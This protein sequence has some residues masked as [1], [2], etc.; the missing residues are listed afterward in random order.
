MLAHPCLPR[1]RSHPK[2]TVA[3][4]PRSAW[5]TTSSPDYDPA[6]CK[7]RSPAFSKLIPTPAVACGLGACTRGRE[8]EMNREVRQLGVELVE[9]HSK[10]R[11]HPLLFFL[12]WRISPYPLITLGSSWLTK[13]FL[14]GASR[15]LAVR[16]EGQSVLQWGWSCSLFPNRSHR[17][18]FLDDGAMKQEMGPVEMLSRQALQLVVW[19]E[20]IPPRPLQQYSAVQHSLKKDKNVKGLFAV[21]LWIK[22][23]AALVHLPRSAFRHRWSSTLATFH[24]NAPAGWSLFAEEG[25]QKGMD[26]LVYFCKMTSLFCDAWE[27]HAAGENQFFQLDMCG[28][29]NILI[30]LWN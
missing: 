6:A 29:S 11:L 20:N 28:R 13:L 14:E 1:V 4:K 9:L 30:Y 15:I 17:V 3:C 16:W 23:T 26:C 8:K 12:M 18:Q 27:R 19:A 21:K 24:W 22:G 5:R 7:R 2:A 25:K 10:K